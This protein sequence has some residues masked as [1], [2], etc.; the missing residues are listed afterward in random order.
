MVVDDGPGG[1]LCIRTKHVACCKYSLVGQRIYLVRK[2]PATHEQTTFWRADVLSDQKLTVELLRATYVTHTFVPHMH[3]AFVVG[4]IEQ[5]A[6]TF[7]YR[8]ERHIASSGS[9]VL[10]NPAEVHTG[11]AFTEGGWTYRTFYPDPVLMQYVASDL[12]GRTRSVPSF[13]QAVVSDQQMSSR[14]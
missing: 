7:A 5:G 1:V 9:V 6:E 14:L 12:A 3:D 8:G 11:S 10:I 13:P 4:V 2:L